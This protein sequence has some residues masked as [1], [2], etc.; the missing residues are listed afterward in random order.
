MNLRFQPE[1][2]LNQV[3]G[4]TNRLILTLLLGQNRTHRR[5]RSLLK[6]L[7]SSTTLPNTKVLKGPRMAYSFDSIVQKCDMTT[8][9]ALP[10][11][12]S[13]ESSNV[14]LAKVVHSLS[15]SYQQSPAPHTT[16]CDYC[17]PSILAGV[18]DV[19]STNP[20][21]HAASARWLAADQPPP[22]PPRPPQMSRI[23]GRSSPERAA[24]AEHPPEAGA[25]MAPRGA[26]GP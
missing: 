19:L 16:H 17:S 11:C 22:Q 25:P 15:K 23:Q 3:S 4:S 18:H 8:P 14:C 2:R 10:F 13:Y 9:Q 20:S 1:I 21:M 26:F 24:H 5:A 7:N 6:H 12:H